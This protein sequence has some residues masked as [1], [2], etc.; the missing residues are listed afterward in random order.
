M[1]VAFINQPMRG[2]RGRIFCPIIAPI[3]SRSEYDVTKNGD[4]ELETNSLKQ[5][6][7]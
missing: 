4:I 3:Y 2:W 7:K 5:D 1:I 6:P